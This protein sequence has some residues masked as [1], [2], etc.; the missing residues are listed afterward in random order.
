MQQSHNNLDTQTASELT[1]VAETAEAQGLQYYSFASKVLVCGFLCVPVHS[2]VFSIFL[3]QDIF[4]KELAK[5][6]AQ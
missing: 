4:A 3:G 5:A 6:K 2:L 1:L